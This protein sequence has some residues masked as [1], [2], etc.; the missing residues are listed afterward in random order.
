MSCIFV[1]IVVVFS[2]AISFASGLNGIKQMMVCYAPLFLAT[3]IFFLVEREK[4]SDKISDLSVEKVKACDTSTAD[5]D[6]SNQQIKNS[7]NKY[8]YCKK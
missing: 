8:I 6:E 2:L 4:I 3:V 1:F 7:E 5:A